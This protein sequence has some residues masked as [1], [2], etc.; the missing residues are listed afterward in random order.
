MYSALIIVSSLSSLILLYLDCTRSS[1]GSIFTRLYA[2]LLII[3]PREHLPVKDCSPPF[4]GSQLALHPS[5]CGLLAGTA[6]GTE[7]RVSGTLMQVTIASIV[8]SLDCCCPQCRSWGSAGL[9]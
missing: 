9:W 7:V 8:P 2:C 4:S 5:H 6:I 1:R 3:L